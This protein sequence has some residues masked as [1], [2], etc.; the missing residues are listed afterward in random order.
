M[1]ATFWRETPDAISRPACA[2][3]SG[4][5]PP[6]RPC[7]RAVVTLRFFLGKLTRN[8]GL[9]GCALSA[10]NCA[11]ICQIFNRPAQICW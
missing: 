8:Y 3:C 2:H 11:S 4:Q 6:V 7:A 1:I 5:R 10:Q 9:S